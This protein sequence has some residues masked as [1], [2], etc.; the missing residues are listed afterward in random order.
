MGCHCLLRL[1]GLKKAQFSANP[2]AF[3]KL[4]RDGWHGNVQILSGHLGD[5]LASI[6]VASVT[7][8]MTSFPNFGKSFIFREAHFKHIN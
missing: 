7:T 4:G 2:S 1:N 8:S 6:A 5:S 3:A